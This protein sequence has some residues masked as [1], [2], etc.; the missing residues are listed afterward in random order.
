MKQI[1]LGFFVLG[2]T[3]IVSASTYYVSES[4]AGTG[5]GTSWTN[6][7]AGNNLQVIIDASISG[8]EV[9]VA[10]GTYVPTSTTDR[11]LSF[12]M[13]ND[14]AI[15]GGFQ[16]TESQL[17]ERI[18]SCGSCTV[19]SGEIGTNGITDNSY[20]VVYNEEVTNT[21]VLDGF[22]ISDGNDDRTPTSA[23][24]GLGGGMYNHGFGSTGF[25]HPIIRNTIFNNNYASWGAGAFNNGYD[26]GNAEPY[27]LNCIFYE[28][29]AYIEAGG[30]DSYGVGG[31]ASPTVVNTL[32]Y[33]NTSATNVGAMYAWGGNG[34]NSQPVLINCVFANN[35]ATNGYGG[36]FIA[37]NLNENGA[38]SSGSCVVTL[39]NCI[40]WN[41]TATGEGPQFYIRGDGA[42]V[43][44]SY[45]AIDLTGQT[46]THIIS[47][48]GTGNLNE[49]PLFLNLSNG[50]GTDNCWLTAD[51]GLQLAAASPLINAGTSLD[52]QATDIMGNPR[53]GNVDI[54]AYEFQNLTE[55]VE[56]KDQPLRIYPNP[57]TGF[58]QLELP[59]WKAGEQLIVRNV[60]GEVLD[61]YTPTGAKFVWN[62]NLSSGVY[63]LDYLGS[64]TRLIIK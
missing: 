31:N 44:A 45:S 2:I 35:S 30:M 64:T 40:V 13:K 59:T 20:T 18:F 17:S 12:H 63:I 22:I 33:G 38:A 16:G 32:F 58:V 51:D 49:T 34:G 46:G 41:N 60:I 61:T 6:A 48:A 62:R 24:D 52:A 57:S 37:D 3:Q 55:V 47:G 11:S 15:Y 56:L 29:H 14:V 21:A 25:C 5:D 7:A 26:G 10:C 23:G 36:A 9:W 53:A 54:G 42:Q 43:V 8:D 19:L 1:I 4:G 28:N 50:R 27:Y 39:Q